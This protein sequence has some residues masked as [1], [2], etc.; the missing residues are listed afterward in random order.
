M[1]FEWASRPERSSALSSPMAQIIQP[2]KINA[3]ILVDDPMSNNW[4]ISSKC[5]QAYLKRASN[6]CRNFY[7]GERFVELLFE[8]RLA[9]LSRVCGARKMSFVLGRPEATAVELQEKKYIKSYDKNLRRNSWTYLV[10]GQVLSQ[11]VSFDPSIV[12]LIGNFT[13]NT[14]N[15]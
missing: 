12:E 8:D 4:Q 7:N 3:K 15:Y 10:L 14:W 13:S 11:I 5:E 1:A 9:T 6:K 2:A